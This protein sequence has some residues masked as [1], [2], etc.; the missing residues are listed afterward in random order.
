M[1]TLI[2]AEGVCPSGG[3]CG[4]GGSAE[5]AVAARA[6]NHIHAHMPPASSRVCTYVSCNKGFFYVGVCSLG[7]RRRHGDVSGGKCDKWHLGVAVRSGVGHRL[8]SHV[9]TRRIAGVQGGRRRPFASRAAGPACVWPQPLL[10]RE[11]HDPSNAFISPANAFSRDTKVAAHSSIDGK[12][13]TADLQLENQADALL[14]SRRP[15]ST[16][17]VNKDGTEEALYRSDT[18]RP[19]RQMLLS[20]IVTSVGRRWHSVKETRRGK[21]IAMYN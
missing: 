3:P 6:S 16:K 1:A 9:W 8:F 19:A 18:A 20:L 21:R 15:L 13:I 4:G 7:C 2:N 5:P 10:G 14:F 11:D 17:S 12:V